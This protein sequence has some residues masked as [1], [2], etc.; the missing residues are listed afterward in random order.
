MHGF[1]EGKRAGY[2]DG[3]EHGYSDG[4]EA[5]KSRI[6]A[7]V[8]GFAVALLGC[9]VMAGDAFGQDAFAGLG[10]VLGGAA[11]MG[12]AARRLLKHRQRSGGG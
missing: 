6:G 7:V 4:W 1:Q 2:E 9:G 12:I 3:F 8:P 11:W 10:T 5:L